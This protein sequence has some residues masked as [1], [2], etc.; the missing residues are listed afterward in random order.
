MDTNELIQKYNQ[1]G[2][3]YTSYPPVPFWKIQRWNEEDWIRTLT[4]A[5]QLPDGKAISI[6]VH[7]PYCDSLCT[8]CGCHKYITTNH[9]V[10]STYIDA[11]LKEWKFVASRLSGKTTISEIHL[12]GGTP[13]FFAPSELKRLIEGL[14][15]LFPLSETVELGF[16]AH[17]NS[18][19]KEHLEVLHQLGFTRISFGIQDYDPT[20][21][22][23][24]HR[25]QTMDQVRLCHETAEKTGY[26][27][28]SHDLV[29]G[30]PKQTIQGFEQTVAQT[31]A[32]RPQRLSLYSYAHVPWVKG[33][34]QRGFDER[35]LPSPELKRALYELAKERFLQAGYQEIAMDH[36]ALEKDPL[37]I[38]YNSKKLHRNFM[39]YTTNTT[40]ILI[41][42]GMSAIY[43]SWYGY[44]QNE[45]DLRNYLKRIEETGFAWE[46]GH[47]LTETDLQ[48][49]KHINAL[50]CN[51]ETEIAENESIDLNTLTE[52][53]IPMVKD[54]LIEMAIRKITVTEKGKPFVRNVCMAFDPYLETPVSKPT[55]SMTI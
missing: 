15:A 34:G 23:A 52:K 55:F 51:F 10:E 33:T 46:K 40:R 4:K 47:R 11:V 20:V 6:Y 39:G 36:F 2:P 35:D 8:F 32:F 24:I 5:Q 19:T 37:A 21:Q 41:G 29:F 1:P 16:E 3:R 7:L 49:R 44:A 42:L 13:T 53:L 30:L 50:M 28:I 54:G 43:D 12:G 14:T 27:S 22:K 26:T 45:K 31:I 48:T 38:A 18:T 9:A 17:P 25:I